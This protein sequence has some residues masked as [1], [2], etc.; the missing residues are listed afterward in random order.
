MMMNK[1][2]Q[3]FALFLV[4]FT[5]LLCILVVALYLYQQGNTQ[6]SLVSPVSVLNTRDDLAL[7]ELREVQL[8][9]TS[10]ANANGNFGDESFKTSFKENYINGVMGDDDMKGFLFDGLFMGG[11]E[12][13]EQDKGKNLL[14]DGIYSDSLVYFEGDNLNFGRAKIEKRKLLVAKNQSKID[15]PVYF[16]FEFDKKYLINKNGEVVRA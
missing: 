13:R 9:K 12:I 6:A 11:V 8:I 7:F 5:L 3:I 15:F 16:R 2:G 1:R 14:E 10:F 4:F